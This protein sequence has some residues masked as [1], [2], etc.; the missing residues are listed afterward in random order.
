ML[1]SLVV[2]LML[3]SRTRVGRSA[4]GPVAQPRLSLDHFTSSEARFT[5]KNTALILEEKTAYAMGDYIF[6]DEGGVRD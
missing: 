3:L 4:L 5:F 2:S 6:E 1:H